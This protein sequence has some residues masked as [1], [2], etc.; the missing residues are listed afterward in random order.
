[1]VIR[2]VVEHG[3]D[4]LL[5]VP[6]DTTLQ[7][8][9]QTSKDV[10]HLGEL[11]DKPRSVVVRLTG[12]VFRK[13][14]VSAHTVAIWQ[15]GH[16]EPW[17]LVSS[18]DLGRGLVG[19]YAQRMQ[20]EALFRDTKSGGFEC[21][22]SRVLRAEVPN[23]CCSASCWPSGAPCCWVKP[24]SAPARFQPTVVDGTPSASCAAAWTGLALH[25]DPTSS[26]GSS[27]RQKLS[28]FE[29]PQAPPTRTSS[30]HDMPLAHVRR[31]PARRLA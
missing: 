19:M 4:Y 7:Q 25:P 12:Q 9:G 11:L 27:L 13:H 29:G 16:Q 1:M 3:W 20:V 30:H 23:V 2:L 18:L 31:Q 21:E 14:S 5:R 22:L 6:Q 26:S 28:G 8:P 10:L 17:L 24:L 15:P